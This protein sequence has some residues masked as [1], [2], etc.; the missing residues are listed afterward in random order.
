MEPDTRT[1][2]RRLNRKTTLQ[3]RTVGGRGPQ[4]IAANV[5]T[6][7]IVTS[8]NDDLNPRDWSAIWPL[9]TRPEQRR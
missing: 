6:L 8:C 4:L 2:V 7:F 9:P 1:P 3:R 5:D